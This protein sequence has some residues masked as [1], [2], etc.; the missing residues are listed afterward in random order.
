MV[1]WLTSWALHNRLIVIML[2]AALFGWGVLSVQRNPIDAIPDLSENQ[3]IVFTEWMGRSPQI[4]EDQVT[5]P[6]VSNLQGIPKV[7]NIRGASMFGMSFVYIIFEDDVDIYWA[8]TRVAERL[9]FAQRLLPAGVMPTLGPD[10][11]GVG[12]IYWYTLDAPGM[13]L[14]EQRALQDWYIKFALQTTP[15]VAEVA[16]FGGFEKQ[17]Q[18]VVDPLKLQ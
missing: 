5:Y 16:S 18:I 17:Y 8:R 1:K 15:G 11:T 4:L 2:A 14:A 10:G 3:V 9:S 12:H 7:K 13:D 6:L